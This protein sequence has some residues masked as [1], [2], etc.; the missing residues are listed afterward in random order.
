MGFILALLGLLGSVVPVL[1]IGAV[2]MGVVGAVLAFV[3]LRA[4]A[5]LGAGRRLALA[6]VILGSAAL[7]VG[8]AINVAFLSAADDT[9][10]AADDLSTWQPL[11][12]TDDDAD[13]DAEADAGT[14]AEDAAA[15]SDVEPLNVV[16]HAF[17]DDGSRWWYVVVVDNPNP[18]LVFARSGGLGSRITVEALDADG[19]ILDSSSAF[20]TLLPG[21]TVIE[22]SFLSIGDNDIAELNVRGP[23]PTRANTIRP[24]S[25][26]SFDVSDVDSTTDRFSTRVSGVVTSTFAEDQTSL[27]V[28]VVARNAEGEIVGSTFTFID[29][30]PAGGSARFETSFFGAGAL[31][32]GATFEVSV[33]P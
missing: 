21:R 7:V 4:A 8:V 31:P 33:T 27:R 30:L 29:R 25:I 2:V 15:T 23:E 6:G 14:D 26:G 12:P 11:D 3:G 24:D 1:G 16:E 20:A 22:G 17:G 9:V 13:P 28:A 19:V 32:D 10:D 18:D 5:R